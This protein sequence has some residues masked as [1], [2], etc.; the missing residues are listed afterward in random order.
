MCLSLM[1]VPWLTQ[2]IRGTQVTKLELLGKKLSQLA[3][4]VFPVLPLIV[5]NP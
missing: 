2:A 4:L 5:A 3:R 1:F